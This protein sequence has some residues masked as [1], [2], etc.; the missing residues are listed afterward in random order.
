MHIR[1]CGINCT[2]SN[3]IKIEQ[4]TGFGDFLFLRLKSRARFYINGKSYEAEPDD[5]ILYSKNAPQF[6]ESTGNSVYVDDYIFFDTDNDKD[7]EFIDHLN[8]KFNQLL[9]LPDTRQFMNI[10]QMICMESINKSN[11]YNESANCLLRYFLIKLSES[12][13]LEFSGKDRA[14]FDRLNELRLA[15]Y[16]SPAQKW[17]VTDMA[18]YVSFSPSY[19]QSIYKKLF[20][21]SCMADLIKSRMNYAKELLST[22]QLPINEIAKCCGYDSNIYFSRHFKRNVGFTPSE[23]RNHIFSKQNS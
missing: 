6:Y 3:G 7:Q 12:M 5:I 18:N 10:H 17:T 8:L 11:N 2:H 9:R 1:F 19:F 15:L 23:Y 22:T 20:H 16:N 4:P 14:L 13:N 21:I